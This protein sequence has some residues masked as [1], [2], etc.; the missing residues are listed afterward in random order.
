MAATSPGLA[1]RA[2]RGVRWN[3]LGAV[4]RIAAT[5]I[6]QIVL[7]RL[8]GPEPFGL[9]GYAFLTVTLL[10]LVVEMGLQNA[11]MQVPQLDDP[12]VAT[13]VG[14]LLLV[15]AIAATAV[16][17]L[18]DLIAVHV[19]ANAAAAP[20]LRAM[21][22][23]LVIG[24]T[25]AAANA[26]L[27]RDLEFKVIQLAALGSYV[28]G[29]LIVG[30]TAALMGLGVWSLVLAWHVQTV[31]ACAFM[32]TRSPRPLK[33]A[34][35]LRPL[36][37]AGFGRVVMVT[38]MVNWVIDNGPHTA[39]GRWLGASSLGLY[40][41]ANNLV[42]VPADHL[43]RNLQTVLF[44][45]AAR[46][47]GNDAGI[48]RAYLTVLGGVGV[49]SFPTF[50]FV[51]LESD[52]VVDLL[53]GHKWHAAAAV[54]VP[55]SLAMVLHA[56]EAMC[57]PILG[58]RGEP[59]AEL[60]IKLAMLVLTLATLAVTARW[61]LVAVGW[62]VAFVFLARWIWL[63]AA[64][65]KR[66]AIS[67]AAFGQAMAGSFVLGAIAAAVPFA[68]DQGLQ[69]LDA[70]WPAAWALAAAALA[71]AALILAATLLVPQVVLGAHLLALAQRLFDK[72]PAWTT[73]PGLR[74]WPVRPNAPRAHRRAGTRRSFHA[75]DSTAQDLLNPAGAVAIAAMLALATALVVLAF[76]KSTATKVMPVALLLAG[77]CLEV[78]LVKAPYV[79]I[80]L[81]ILPERP[82]LG[83]R[84]D[85][86][87][88]RLRLPAGAD[89]RRPVPAL[90]RLRRGD[91]RLV[92]GRPQRVRPLRRH[93]GDRSSTCG[94]RACIAASPASTRPS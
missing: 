47:Q 83:L 22:P 44:P 38:N 49:L 41:V 12:V 88:R 86:C 67:A 29:Y 35:P 16:F 28:V 81:Q 85:G 30:I 92:R 52:R 37:V 23:T 21:A 61:S 33:P 48:R 6:S 50:T 60:R 69:R 5:F 77:F 80:G 39:I 45:L 79:Q 40:T 68:L 18:A 75:M 13:A 73:A 55:L 64:V 10:A 3:Y 72:R 20:V 27:A 87:D 53:L 51:A 94:W 65:C 14:R 36:P 90:A 25:S 59:R 2:L 89:Q 31:L 82:H 63:N 17:A 8:L 11:L 7:A 19:F 91:D 70:G 15:S 34:N 71:T 57:G 84:A 42:K 9:F 78:F 32:V 43:V 62:G 56:V 93:R 46:A 58:G 76:I 66:L 26:M 54:L 74:E 24:A 4:G 1:A